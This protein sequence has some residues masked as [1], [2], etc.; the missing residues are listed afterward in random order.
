M[1][2]RRGGEDGSKHGSG[3]KVKRREKEKHDEPPLPSPSSRPGSAFEINI[4]QSPLGGL[5]MRTIGEEIPGSSSFSLSFRRNPLLVDKH[6]MV[7]IN[8]RADG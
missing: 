3:K 4:F 8:G 7:R 6:T 1:M 5:A 2:Q